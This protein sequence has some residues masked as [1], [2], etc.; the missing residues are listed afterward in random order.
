MADRLGKNRVVSQW[1][2]PRATG[3]TEKV[4][5]GYLESFDSLSLRW[6]EIQ[7]GVE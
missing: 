1:C 3:C 5:D 4:V 2:F 6:I 7:R